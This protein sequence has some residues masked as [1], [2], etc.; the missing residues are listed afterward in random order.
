MKLTIIEINASTPRT[1]KR[2]I[3]SVALTIG[4]AYGAA[5]A[6]EKGKTAGKEKPAP[7]IQEEADD[8]LRSA[9][10]RTRQRERRE[11]RRESGDAN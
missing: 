6:T 4:V 8:L 2:T 3:F 1:W 11:R 5:Y 10:R 7:T 9:A